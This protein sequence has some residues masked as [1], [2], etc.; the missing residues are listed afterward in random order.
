METFPANRIQ[1]GTL[2]IEAPERIRL[3]SE[4][5]AW[6]DEIE[7]PAAVLPVFGEIG[8]NGEVK[9]TWITWTVSGPVTASN[10]SAHYGGV[11]MIPKI[12]QNLGEIRARG[13]STYAHAVA[14]AIAEGRPTRF[15][16]LPG[17]VA[18]RTD[19]TSIMDGRPCHTF[20]IR[21]Q[22]PEGSPLVCCRE[23][24]LKVAEPGSDVRETHV[25][26]PEHGAEVRA[27]IAAAVAKAC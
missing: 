20:R 15:A 9:D 16:L 19:F 3:D 27:S 17:F 22:R 4:F 6:F 7:Q 10:W 21:Q 23:G 24:C 13:Q 18:E 12:N 25:W 1:I 14:Q 8:K 26:C 5:A 11:C 2:T